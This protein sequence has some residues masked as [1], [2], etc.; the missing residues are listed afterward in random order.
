[1]HEGADS[2]ILYFRPDQEP[3]LTPDLRSPDVDPAVRETLRVNLAIWPVETPEHRFMS[4]IRAEVCI[5]LVARG[6]TLAGVVAI[7]WEPYA[8]D[9]VA[10]VAT[11]VHCWQK[12]ISYFYN[13]AL[14]IEELVQL[15]QAVESISF[16]VPALS[17]AN[18]T[19]E[20]LRK[21]VTL[22]T[23][24]AGLRWQRAFIY[25]FRESYPS[26]AL[27]VMAVGGVGNPDWRGKH[28]E[29]TEKCKTIVDYLRSAED[30][31]CW[32]DD[33]LYKLVQTDA[34]SLTIPRDFLASNT[35]LNGIFCGESDPNLE[36]RRGD[37][38]A[39]LQAAES[40]SKCLR[41]ESQSFGHF[42]IPL[43]RQRPFEALGFVVLDN[44]YA[45]YIGSHPDLA[46]TRV[47]CHLLAPLL[48][49]R[50]LGPEDWHER[51]RERDRL[52]ETLMMAAG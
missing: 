42:L 13:Y 11:Q 38:T 12:I 32:T 46:V 37:E 20:F 50:D 3:T 1:M 35:I 14:R 15:Q 47:F 33:P 29:L 19:S 2:R 16:A 40:W 8:L 49:E 4:K 28:R 10:E 30:G 44:P 6:K 39:Y 45:H 5:P 22:L 9:K 17:A 41:L 21:A 48:I 23:C 27:C 24:D 34:G 31:L 36:M 25:L 43:I 52:F 26:D 18:T 7:R 51:E